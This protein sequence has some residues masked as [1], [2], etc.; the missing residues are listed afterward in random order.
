[1]VSGISTKILSENS[2]EFCDRFK[3]LPQERKA[4][5]NSDIINNEIVAK[6]DKLL[7]VKCISSKQQKFSPLKCLN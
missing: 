1:M 2:N 5:N 6:A 3:F 7:E 4:G